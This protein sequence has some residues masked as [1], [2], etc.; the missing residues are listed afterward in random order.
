MNLRPIQ[1]TENDILVSPCDGRVLSFGEIK[2]ADELILV[3]GFKHKFDDFLFGH[4][5]TKNIFDLQKNRK[6]NIYQITIYLSP[7]DC[8]RIYSPGELTMKEK[9]KIPGYLE[10]VNPKYLQKNKHVLGS[11]ERVTVEC[12]S[13]A[14]NDYVYLTMVGAINVG[15]IEV[16]ME[17]MEVKRGEEIG[18]FNFGSTV[19]VI[20][21]KDENKKVKFTLK[22]NQL[23]KI[24]NALYEM[25][26]N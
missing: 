13:I 1:S 26:T 14:V 22:E 10:S 3:K 6:K 21:T 19:V 8:H 2:S 18:W 24:G 23:V 16:P 4:S 9:Y 5:N 17:K 7:G 11:N 12:D 20:F 15:C 25:E